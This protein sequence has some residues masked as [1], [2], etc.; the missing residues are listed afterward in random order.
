MGETDFARHIAGF[1]SRYL[2]G[3]RNLS[4]N[5]IA[6]YRDAVKLFLVFCQAD[7]KIRP[8]QI[9]I[10][11]ISPELLTAYLGWLEGVRRCGIATRNQ[12]LAAFKSFFHYVA[13]PIATA[14]KKRSKN[15]R[16]GLRSIPEQKNVP[17]GR[18]PL[19]SPRAPRIRT[20]PR[21]ESGQ[22]GLQESKANTT[23]SGRA[24]WSSWKVAFYSG[25]SG[26]FHRTTQ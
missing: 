12:R 15:E 21:N 5:T 19:H 18:P 13:T 20:P 10:S 7:R 9:Q 24:D 17:R 3:Q 26:S 1:L 25:S 4:T 11:D 6:S 2:P 22:G 14:T 16:C 23:L 8:D